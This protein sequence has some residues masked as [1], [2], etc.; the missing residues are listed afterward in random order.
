V[1][2]AAEAVFTRAGLIQRHY[3]GHQ[4]GVTDN[5]APRL[6]AYDHAPIEANMVFAVE[7]GAYGDPASG[8]GVRFEKVV[9][10]TAAGPEILSPFEWGLSA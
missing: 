1:W 7:P 3:L 10:V 9:R 8:F 6:A 4:V 5:E 2:A